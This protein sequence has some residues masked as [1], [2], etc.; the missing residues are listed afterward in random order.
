MRWLTATHPDLRKKQSRQIIDACRAKV[1]F[2]TNDGLGIEAYIDPQ[3]ARFFLRQQLRKLVTE[4][5]SGQLG[6]L[7]GHENN[8]SNKCRAGALKNSRHRTNRK[9]AMAN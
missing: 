3:G 7:E 8:G 1:D 4:T 5:I 6:K 9:P 2:A